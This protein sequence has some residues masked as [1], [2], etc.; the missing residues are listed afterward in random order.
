[1]TY[2]PILPEHIKC[3]SGHARMFFYNRDALSIW[4]C[5][6]CELADILAWLRLEYGQE[7]SRMFHS[8]K[9]CGSGM[10][11]WKETEIS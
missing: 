1:M 10:E 3:D 9:P 11:S 7:T 6:I 8:T 5:P 4:R 2:R